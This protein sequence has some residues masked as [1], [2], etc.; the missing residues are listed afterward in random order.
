MSDSIWNTT[1]T[2]LTILN[3]YGPAGASS[4][5]YSLPP[6]ELRLG[7]DCRVKPSNDEA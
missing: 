4:R 6:G 1:R 2:D 5:W 7:M 3:I